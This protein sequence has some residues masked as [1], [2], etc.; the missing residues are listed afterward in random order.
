MLAL[1]EAAFRR[2]GHV[3]QGLKAH[4]LQTS[5]GE[6]ELAPFQSIISKTFQKHH[7]RWAVDDGPSI[8]LS[9]RLVPDVADGRHLSTV[10]NR[11]HALL[12]CVPADVVDNHGPGIR[13]T[14]GRSAKSPTHGH[15]Q[16]GEDV[17]VERPGI[18]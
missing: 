9:G 18:A 6:L 1:H 3:L 7:P 2:C 5:D 4:G 16:D 12:R 10:S 15:V 14:A 11:W 8:K 17:L 13:Q